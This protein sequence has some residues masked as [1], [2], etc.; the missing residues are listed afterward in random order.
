MKKVLFLI[1]AVV[2]V[3]ALAT[4]SMA[5]FK[6]WGH[7]EFQTQYQVNM[8][9]NLNTSTTPGTDNQA[10]RYVSQRARVYLQYG[11]PKVARAVVGFEI[12]GQRWGFAPAASNSDANKNNAAVQGTD[13]IAV[14]VKWAF[15]EFVIP[16]T[17]L[18][19]T[20]GMQGWYYGGRLFSNE[21][22][23]GVRLTANF[24]PHQ[25]EAFWWRENDNSNTTYN[26]N[27]LYGLSY[28]LQ[29]KQFGVNAYA[30]YY[31]NLTN[32]AYAD[33]PWFAGIGANFDPGNWHFEGQFSY[34]GGNRDY[35]G[36]TPAGAFDS[37]SGYAAELK[38]QY[39]IGPGLF[40]GAEGFYSTGND[41]DDT[42]TNKRFMLVTNDECRSNFGNWRTVFFYRATGVF[43]PWMQ[44][45]NENFQGTWYGNVNAEYSP[46]AWLRLIANYMYIGD[47]AHGTPGPGKTVNTATGAQ[48]TSD[49]DVIGSEINLIA[50]LSIAKGFLFNAGFGYF[51]PNG[52][53][54]NKPGKDADNGYALLTRLIYAF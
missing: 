44:A 53:M 34:D 13:Q 52:D 27:D 20:I 25:I 47:S 38:A 3:L 45:Y 54:F 41:A 11:D 10:N 48:Q 21:D 5:Q 14:E 9:N 51:I 18:S 16:K 15:L 2:L 31:N 8:T 49:E 22:N 4:P 1:G 42:T 28:K 40:V 46:T 50:S 37:Y 19:M 36:P 23:P 7:I 35:N 12:D 24:A 43:G 26:V 29:Q 39:R 6:T 33:H 30:A 32:A 17:P